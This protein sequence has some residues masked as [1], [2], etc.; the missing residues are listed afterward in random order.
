[1]RTKRAQVKFNL[2]LLGSLHIQGMH[3]YY[4]SCVLCTQRNKISLN[5]IN[6]IKTEK[7]SVHWDNRK[8]DYVKEYDEIVLLKK[9]KQ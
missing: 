6:F 7:K 1:M 9:K 4:L 8:A 3:S 5:L 2:K